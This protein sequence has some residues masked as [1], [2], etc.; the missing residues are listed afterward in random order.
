MKKHI[1]YI[2]FFATSLWSCTDSLD[3]DPHD[4]YTN[5]AV[6]ENI[7]NVDLYVNNLYQA[8]YLYSEVGSVNLT[9]GFS[10][11]LKYSQT[12]MDTEHNRM[13]LSP[14]YLTPANAEVISPW[15]ATYSQI[16]SLNEFIVD[17][18][19][20]GGHLNKEQL[21]IRL[22][23]AKFLRAFLYHKLI[24]RHG[25]V[26]MRVS[27]DRLDGPQDKNKKRSTTEE[28][29]NWVID[30]LGTIAPLLPYKWD[31]ANEGRITRGAAYSLIARSA[32]YAERWDEAI[33]AAKQVE[34]IA[35]TQNLY[36]VID[37]FDK[38]FD[39]PHNKE[40]ILGVYYKRP[41]LTNSFD[42]YF[43]PTG[44]MERR[45]GYATPTENLVSQ[46]D[47]KVGNRW[48]R[49][50]WENST[51]SENPYQNRDPRFYAT[52]L[53]NGAPWKGRN[54]ETYVGGTDG[55]IEYFDGNSRNR[56][57]TG[58]FVRKFLENKVKDFVTEK[59]DQYWIEIRYAEIMLILSEAY[60][61]GKNDYGMAYKYLNMVRERVSVALPALATKMNDEEYL[62]DLQREK[63]CEFAFE[64]H[65]YWDLRRWNKAEDVL[66][67]TRMTGM[68]IVKDEK[69]KALSYTLVDC[70]KADRFFPE[71]YYI[72]PI[73]EF[74]IRNNLDCKQDASWQ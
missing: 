74:E 61:R 10:D 44:D 37:A 36:A 70:D 13:C 3:V 52:I 54:L 35:N 56:T 12:Y 38:V 39:T 63:M 32:L 45:G 8:L 64:G 26:V 43:A 4:K 59:G 23:E 2:L 62:S 33:K 1:L 55:Y 31:D 40:I 22:A 42:N 60:A 71:R 66:H 53:Y 11:I 57:V 69:T 50:D 19:K 48:E 9:D 51:H 73:P 16:K 5:K 7:K 28:S 15:A 34:N 24:V 58:Y 49:F 41:T 20:F 27:N 30:E 65:R 67:G 6:W 29:W 21:D 25:G 14:S 68:Q 17:A 72:V 47:I 18:G 46:F